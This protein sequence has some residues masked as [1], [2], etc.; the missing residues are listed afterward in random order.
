MFITCNSV[1]V[2]WSCVSH[3]FLETCIAYYYAVS[4][5][6]WMLSGFH[7]DAFVVDY[8]V[9]FVL[10]VEWLQWLIISYVIVMY[11]L[12]DSR[13]I[14]KHAISLV[15]IQRNEQIPTTN[16]TLNYSSINYSSLTLLFEWLFCVLYIYIYNK[17]F[18]TKLILF[19]KYV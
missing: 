19:T 1:I 18:I 7:G 16:S 11:M 4:F 17:P 3:P 8:T 14:C 15:N 10:Y 2:L 5:H 6:I 13:W 12:D 9:L